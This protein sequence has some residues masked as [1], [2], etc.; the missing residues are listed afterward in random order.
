[1]PRI[2]SFEG[3]RQSFPDD[4]TDAEISAALNAI[5]ASTA[6]EPP[7]AR[8]WTDTLMDWVPSVGGA[9][10]TMIGAAAGSLGASGGGAVG[11]MVGSALQQGVNR[12]RGAEAPESP[13]GELTGATKSG[14][15][16]GAAGAALGAA[17]TALKASGPALEAAGNAIERVGA[18]PAFSKLSRGGAVLYGLLTGHVRTAAEGAIAGPEA[19]QTAGRVLSTVGA[20]LGAAKEAATTVAERLAAIPLKERLAAIPQQVLEK[21]EPAS[22]HTIADDVGLVRA[23]LSKHWSA[24]AAIKVVAAGDADYANQL[25]KAVL[26]SVKTQGVRVAEPMQQLRTLPAF[27][28]LPR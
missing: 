3:K 23:A 28:K 4:A 27:Q 7:K 5:P 19:V 2:V 20:R 17:G 6:K 12:L 13:L 11:G 21:V 26:D 1:M 16:T 10:G 15:V 14:A 8:T 24:D 18:S 9:A 25:T 22:V